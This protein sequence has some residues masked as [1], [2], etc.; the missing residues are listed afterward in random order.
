MEKFVD[1]IPT[2]EEALPG[3]KENSDIR[4]IYNALAKRNGARNWLT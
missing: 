1:Y 2:A 3:T 4:G